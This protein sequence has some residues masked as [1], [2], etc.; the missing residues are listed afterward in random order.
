MHERALKVPFRA[1]QRSSL[2]LQRSLL[3]ILHLTAPLA[4][5]V[6]CQ[7]GCKFAPLVCTAS[8]FVPSIGNCLA[9]QSCLPA[10]LPAIFEET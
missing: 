1:A 6:R 5:H 10:C 9:L 4:T 2:A 3:A 8:K 7:T